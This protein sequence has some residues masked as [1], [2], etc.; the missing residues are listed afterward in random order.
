VS[1]RPKRERLNLRIPADLLRW[2][3]KYLR[4]KNRTVTQEVI[5][6]FTRMRESDAA[7]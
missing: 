4:A 6:H 3:K 5:D 2:V 7:K 1:E